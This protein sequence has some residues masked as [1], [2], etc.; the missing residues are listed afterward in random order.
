MLALPSGRCALLLN[1]F[2]LKG[3]DLGFNLTFFVFLKNLHPFMNCGLVDDYAA[4][5]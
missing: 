5:S 4:G 1:S 3:Q 2:V